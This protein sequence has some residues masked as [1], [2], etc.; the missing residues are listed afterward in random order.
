MPSKNLIKSKK[1]RFVLVGGFN[2]GLDFGLMNL[3]RILGL[4][5][6]LANT[7][8][9]GIAMLSSFFLNKRWT[10]RNAGEDY[11][12]QIVLFFIFT[13]IGIW[14]I[15]NG[16]IWLIKEFV[17]HFGLPPW[18]FDNT[19]KVVASVPSL[20]WNYMTYSKFVFRKT[21]Q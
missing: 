7:I 1:I 3:F 19:T 6:L 5:L 21:S 17:P 15:Q 12:R 2:T 14:A 10:F 16:V 20:I 8:S 4:E 9:T 11:F 18:I 13:I